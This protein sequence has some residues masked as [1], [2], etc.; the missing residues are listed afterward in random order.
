V[1]AFEITMYDVEVVNVRASQQ[2]GEPNVPIG[3]FARPKD[4]DVMYILPFLKKHRAR[5][6]RPESCDLFGIQQCT[7]CSVLVEER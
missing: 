6:R 5:E 7:R 4:N 3:L 1:D 2:Q